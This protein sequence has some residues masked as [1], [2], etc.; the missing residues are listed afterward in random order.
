VR[1]VDAGDELTEGAADDWTIETDGFGYWA[2]A[3]V[4]PGANDVVIEYEREVYR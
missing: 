1:F 4:A 2:E 3:D